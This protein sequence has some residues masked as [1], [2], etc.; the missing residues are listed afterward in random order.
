MLGPWVLQLDHTATSRRQGSIWRPTIWRN[1]SL[2]PEAY[3]AAYTLQEIL[4][5]KSDD[6]VGENQNIR[7][8]GQRRQFFASRHPQSFNALMKEMQSLLDIRVLGA[9]SL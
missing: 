2:G 1:G 6:A 3:G 9:D 8:V 7:I 4:T 5:V